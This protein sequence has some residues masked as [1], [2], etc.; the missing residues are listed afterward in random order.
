MAIFF[1]ALVVLVAAPVYWFVCWFWPFT[2]CRRCGGAG[3]KSSPS[4]RNYRRCRKCRGA[5][6]RLRTGRRLFN[7]LAGH[8]D[9]AR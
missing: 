2:Y 8:K 6:E 1:T 7:W 5:G 9:A 3:R 4:G